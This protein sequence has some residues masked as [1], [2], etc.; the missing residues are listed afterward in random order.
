M[1]KSKLYYKLFS[2]NIIIEH[3]QLYNFCLWNCHGLPMHITFLGKEPLWYKSQ[4]DVL[5][6]NMNMDVSPYILKFKF[7]KH[8][9]STMTAGIHVSLFKSKTEMIYLPKNVC[10]IIIHRRNTSSRYVLIISVT[11]KGII[12]K[13][14]KNYKC[15]YTICML[16][17]FLL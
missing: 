13:I 9:C 12:M 15:S 8:T 5:C 4:N 11:S 14:L 7:F 2:F 1:K 6:S 16:I 17:Y 3:T 10:L